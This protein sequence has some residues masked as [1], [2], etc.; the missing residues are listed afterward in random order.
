MMWGAGKAETETETGPEA[1]A[2]RRRRPLAAS[3]AADG[4]S[5]KPHGGEKKV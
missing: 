5:W 2:W 1:G 4:P 3:G